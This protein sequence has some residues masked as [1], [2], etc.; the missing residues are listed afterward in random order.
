[1]L[2][3]TSA[4]GT[5]TVTSTTG[6]GS[7]T[8]ATASVS[9]LPLVSER[10][11]MTL[12]PYRAVQEAQEVPEVPEDQLQSPPRPLLPASCLADQPHLRRSAHP[13]STHPS[14]AQ[15]Q[16]QL[17]QLYQSRPAAHPHSRP[18][19]ARPPST[20]QLVAPAALEETLRPSRPQ[21]S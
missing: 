2:T 1:M 10:K 13:P 12:T 21:P 18:P 17:Q 9:V 6:T 8:S 19:L 7:M 14:L 11:R 4:T 15:P 16:S 20:V 3:V 5:V